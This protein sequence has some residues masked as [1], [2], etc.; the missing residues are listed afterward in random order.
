MPR[1]AAARDIGTTEFLVKPFTAG[2]LARRIAHVITKPR[3]FVKAPEYFGPDR[4]R[5]F[6]DG[7]RGP[8]KRDS[9]L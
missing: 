3:D 4:R 5:K 2:D 1:V 6:T 9:D 7:F 8:F